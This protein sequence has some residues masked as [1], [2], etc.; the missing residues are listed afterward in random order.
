MKNESLGGCDKCDEYASRGVA[1]H[2]H[3]DDLQNPNF[4]Y[5][6]NINLILIPVK[7]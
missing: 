1:M 3:G 7:S 5:K 4:I 2:H 6:K